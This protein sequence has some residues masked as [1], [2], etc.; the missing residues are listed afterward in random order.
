MR[1][2]FNLFVQVV[3]CG[4]VIVL[5]K[6]PAVNCTQGLQIL[7]EDN[8]IIIRRMLL[9]HVINARKMTEVGCCFIVTFLECSAILKLVNNQ[10]SV[11]NFKKLF[12]N[13]Q[14]NVIQLIYIFF[15]KLG[16][17]NGRKERCHFWIL[18]GVGCGADS[19]GCE[20]D[21]H[22]MTLRNEGAQPIVDTSETGTAEPHSTRIPGIL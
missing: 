6:M 14:T 2:N 4:N 7:A 8:I 17:K 22:R 5:C 11:L 13:C 16:G 12:G 3:V 20:S 1:L 18:L 15:G 19:V 21:G 9:N 10:V